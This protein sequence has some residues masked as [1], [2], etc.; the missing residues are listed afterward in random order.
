MSFFSR[1]LERLNRLPPVQTRDIVVERDLKVPMKDGVTLLADRFAPRNPSGPLPT[2]LVRSPYGRGGVWGVQYGELF[3]ERGFQVVIQS[4]RGTF[5]SGGDFRPFHTEREDGLATLA[6]LRAQPWFDGRLA[7]MGGSYLGYVQWA[8]GADGAPEMKAHSIEISFS[9]IRSS[10]FSGGAYWL[11]TALTWGLIVKV[12]ERSPI[13]SMLMQGRASKLLAKAFRHLPLRTAD[14]VGIGRPA[15]FM[16]DWMSHAEPGDPWWSPLDHSGRVANIDAPVRLLGGYFD[17]FLPRTLADYELLRAAGKKPYLTLGPWSHVDPAWGSISLNE[18]LGFFRAHLMGD[19]SALRELP[20][21]VH[22]INGEQRDFPE[23]PPPGA[24]KT[25][26][27]LHPGG[28]LSEGAPPP[29]EPDRYRYDPTDPTPSVGGAS[30]SDNTGSRDN[31]KL[32]ARSDV[33]VYTTP[34]LAEDVEIIGPVSA[35]LF[36]K[37]SLPQADFFV[38]LC[39]VHPNGKSMN[40]SDGIFRVT[41]ENVAAEKDGSRKVTVT[42]WPTACRFL[43]GHKIRVQVSSGAH[44]RWARNTGSGEPFDTATRLVA[45]DQTVFHDPERPSAVVLPVLG[46]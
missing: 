30:L 44:P 11:D 28:A 42:M 7:M 36:V 16:R 1:A 32:E 46:R 27:H 35:E 13:L 38:R 8:I 22:V 39:D 12:Q 45:A 2:I 23:W 37:S 17:V 24:M 18:T 21:R 41:P 3:S 6:W 15:P 40:V 29:S 9:E 4:C 14:E 25:R 31:R 43:K 19:R 10:T 26:Y 33:L 20:V 5:G 34:E